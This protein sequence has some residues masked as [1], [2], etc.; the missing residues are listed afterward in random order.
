MFG[1]PTFGRPTPA[2]MREAW[3]SI[4]NFLE[5]GDKIKGDWSDA[6]QNLIENSEDNIFQR[7]KIISKQSQAFSE[8]I[9]LLNKKTY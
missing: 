3:T 4:S 6:K 2:P 9:L 1:H 7:R 5:I 8:E